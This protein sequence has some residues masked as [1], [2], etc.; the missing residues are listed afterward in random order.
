MK[1]WTVILCWAAIVWLFVAEEFQLTNF[2]Q[3]GPSIA[4]IVIA[5]ALMISEMR[6]PFK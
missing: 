6:K 3:L 2:S 4:M 1:Y 5:F